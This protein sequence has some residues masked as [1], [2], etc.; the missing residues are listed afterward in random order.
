MA[1][2]L[3]VMKAAGLGM[4]AA[5]RAGLGA[6]RSNLGRGLSRG[7]IARGALWSGGGALAGGAYSSTRGE[8]FGSGAIKGGMLGAGVGAIGGA[9]G[10]RSI[11]NAG[12]MRYSRAG[13]SIGGGRASSYVGRGLNKLAEYEQKAVRMVAGQSRRIY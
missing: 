13:G 7:R 5:G 10:L 12:A 1:N 3:G 9:A 8:G 11:Y 2:L 6:A 4:G